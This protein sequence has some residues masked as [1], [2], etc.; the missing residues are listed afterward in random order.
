M[1]TKQPLIEPEDSLPDESISLKLR[2]DVCRDIR[3]YGE[4]A[5]CSQNHVVS[6]AVKR[7]FSADKGFKEFVDS[8]PNAGKEATP[9]ATGKRQK[10]VKAA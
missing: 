10:R 3:A 4:Y 6:A 8:N 9:E 2:P 5:K 7:L 1:N